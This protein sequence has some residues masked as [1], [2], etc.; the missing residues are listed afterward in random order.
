MKLTDIDYETTLKI[1]DFEN[2]FD[3]Y[4]SDNVYRYNLNNSIF[5]NID[6]SVI[7]T[8]ELKTPAHWSLISYKLYGTPRL[9]WLLMKIN[10]VS[11][12][13]TFEKLQPG[14]KIKYVSENNVKAILRSLD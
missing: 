8:Y 7:L 1:T 10:N 14:T 2:F 11:L 12:S 5:L 13:E 6:D 9:A 4:E 3:V